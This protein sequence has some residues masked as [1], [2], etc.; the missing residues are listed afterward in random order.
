M[1]LSGVEEEVVI[2]K[3]INE[4]VD[5]IVNFEVLTLA[6]TDPDSVIRFQ[7]RTHQRFF[8]IVLVDF[9]SCT[10]PRAPLSQTSY[11]SALRAI[12]GHPSFDFEGSIEDLREA[13]DAF[14]AWLN[15]EVSV[16]VWL[17]SIDKKGA[18]QISRLS[19]LKMC[20]NISKHNFL[21]LAGVAE[22]LKKT[23]AASGIEA[24]LDD[25]MLAL[26]DFYQRFHTDILEF[27]GSTI[28]KFLNDIRWGIYR[29]M[30]PELLRSTVW[31]E[32]DTRMRRFKYPN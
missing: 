21:R 20:G 22:E 3:A 5:S 1:G 19:F 29:Y 30:Q 32:G 11:L 23:L 2:L 17:P 8:N 10:D 28:A 31:T 18:I 14:V 7:S 25:A 27:H 16:D 13:S 9:L 26:A 4:I 24:D 15:E 6:G 12:C